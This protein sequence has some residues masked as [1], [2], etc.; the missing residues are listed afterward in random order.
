M[1]G[2]GFDA[3][4]KGIG[5]KK[6]ESRLP[7][8]CDRIWADREDAVF[9]KKRLHI[10]AAALVAASV[11]FTG[12]SSSGSSGAASASTG[13]RV[14][15]SNIVVAMAS[16]LVT[17]DPADTNWT[18]DG[19]IQR[20][21]MDGMFG[22][23][24][25]G[26]VIDLLATGYKANSD[27]TQFTITLRKD[28]TFTDGT[29]WNADAA[30]AN[31]NKLSNQTL[32]LRRNGLFAMVDHTEKTDDS[33]IVVHL[34]YPFGAF[35]N[36]LA[37]PAAVMMSPKQIAAGE[38]ACASNPVG[39]GQYKFVEWKTGQYLKLELNPDWW[40][41]DA[42]ASGGKALVAANAGFSTITFKPVAEAATRVS[43]VQ[44]GDADF[45]FPVPSE[46]YSSLKSN[47][48]VKAES[49]ESIVVY[50]LNINT[51]KKNLSD[52]KV[53]Q[54]INYAIDRN[55]YVTV[56]KNGLA[57]VATSQIAPKVQYYKKEAALT[58]NVSKAKQL[59]QE[60]GF[61]NGLNLTL[62][63]SN[64]SESVKAGQFLQQQ[65][66]Q[67]GITVKLVPSETAT[68]NQKIDGFKGDGADAAYDLYYGGWSPSTGDADWALRPCFSNTMFVTKGGANYSYFDNA[69]YETQITAGL[70]SADTKARQA[71]YDKAQDILWDQLPSVP[72]ANNYNT[73][74]SGKH[75]K[76]LSIYPDGAIYFR[77]GV[78]VK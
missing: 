72:L 15:D 73:W 78:Y 44:S 53:R 6:A 65:L 57:S 22:F 71:A 49:N 16:D 26:K 30:I 37:H 24:K 21:I 20:L 52:P 17:L 56:V 66:A 47:S 41:Y 8:K 33:T 11:L 19:G 2:C 36:T 50:Y 29:P 61:A 39:T 3:G 54:A 40:G 12:C 69:D 5:G 27:A 23:D 4:K 9:M 1:A 70:N 38:K 35:I 42:K 63:S 55:A 62:Y 31:L 76:N 67:V 10:L 34:K 64:A 58:Y 77:D 32:G 75:V 43:M 25:D 74:A 51:K 46:S 59:L 18:L 48:S 45:I 7:P 28:V 68:L 60:A 13:E 14:K